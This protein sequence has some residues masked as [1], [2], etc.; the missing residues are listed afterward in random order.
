MNEMK[1][2]CCNCIFSRYQKDISRHPVIGVLRQHCTNE[3]YNSSAYTEEMY[4]ED[5]R[6]GHCRFWA[7]DE[8][9]GADEA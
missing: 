6:T 9:G 2:S 8:E 5:S 3:G 4:L 1:K 7:S